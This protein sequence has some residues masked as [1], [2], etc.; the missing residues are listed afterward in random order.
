MK[1]ATETPS[2]LG[3]FNK[4]RPKFMVPKSYLNPSLQNM[5]E[6]GY[7]GNSKEMI[8]SGWNSVDEEKSYPSIT[9]RN[10]QVQQ[11]EDDDSTNGYKGLGSRTGS[12]SGDEN[13][14]FNSN[15]TGSTRMTEESEEDE[16]P[17][18]LAP[19]VSLI[20]PFLHSE[21][22]LNLVASCIIHRTGLS[23]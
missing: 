2:L 3:N 19:R 23:D 5:F 15:S 14:N 1:D 10:P 7:F 18:V 21:V 20:A 17:P 6:V 9:S 13:N 22:D 11:Q 4:R 8:P 16:D 12:E